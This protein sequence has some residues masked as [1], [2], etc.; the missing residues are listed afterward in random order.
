VKRLLDIQLGRAFSVSKA[1][2]GAGFVEGSP[3]TRCRA[4]LESTPWTGLDELAGSGRSPRPPPCKQ[5]PTTNHRNQWIN[6]SFTHSL[7]QSI[8]ESINHSLTQSITNQSIK[9]TICRFLQDPLTKYSEAPAMSVHDQ[10][11]R[12]QAWSE[13]LSTDFTVFQIRR[14]ITPQSTWLVMITRRCTQHHCHHRL[15]IRNDDKRKRVCHEKCEHLSAIGTPALTTFPT[16]LNTFLDQ[17]YCRQWHYPS[18][19]QLRVNVLLNNINCRNQDAAIQQT[20]DVTWREDAPCEQR[21]V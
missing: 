12:I 20:S 11:P 8:N 9:Q 6:Q 3:S 18:S 19:Y 1:A 13:T 17:S 2:A 14:K 10:Q 21:Q 7:N 15:S 4:R 16:F 5:Q